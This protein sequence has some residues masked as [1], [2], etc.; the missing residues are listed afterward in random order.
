MPTSIASANTTALS[1]ER[2]Y[3]EL[4]KRVSEEK[5][6]ELEA[7]MARVT[8]EELESLVTTIAHPE[9]LL[10]DD[11]FIH[12][13]MF[14]PTALQAVRQGI[15]SPLQFGTLI[16]LWGNLK[17]IL[18]NDTGL[19][20]RPE[21]IPLF[22]A[23]GD[24]N[25][26]A[27]ECI[28]IAIQPPKSHD[29]FF[30]ASPAELLNGVFAGAID[31]SPSEQGFWI[32]PSFTGRNPN[33]NE[34]SII[35]V[36]KQQLDFH[37][38]DFSAD[39]KQQIIPSLELYQLFLS[40]AFLNPVTI[41]PVI[42]ESTVLQIRRNSLLRYR[43]VILPCFGI[44]LPTEADGFAVE[45]WWELTS[46]DLYH[47][48]RA[49]RIG[50]EETQRYIA[51]GDR[52]KAMQKRSSDAIQLYTR[53]H[54]NN[55][56]RLQAIEPEVSRK[57]TILKECPALYQER[58]IIGQL[59]KL[60]QA[61]GML[62]FFLYDMEQFYKEFPDDHPMKNLEREIFSVREPFQLFGKKQGT[63][64]LNQRAGRIL[65]HALLD[66]ISPAPIYLK[67]CKAK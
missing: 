65:A 3:Q 36:I 12:K 35:R 60:R 17:H 39:E 11:S 50:P 55:I 52:F 29:D 46:H 53:H 51:F 62:K 23:N 37:L 45:S 66:A 47:S 43:D 57:Q 15:I 24:R 27:V 61:A 2:K 30:E 5:R 44:G 31:L 54:K 25:P 14:A 13:E 16:N 18:P 58:C 63:P 22:L 33:P 20:E 6:A 28:R 41:N 42:G 34:L 59:K 21:F 49:S 64:R 9:H 48:A 8:P 38:L 40:K 67:K 26:R 56:R 32:V 19:N 7:S 10:K 1:A 4:V